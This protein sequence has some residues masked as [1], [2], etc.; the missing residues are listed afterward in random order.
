MECNDYNNIKQNDIPRMCEDIAEDWILL[1]YDMSKE[2]ETKLIK[3]LL[4]LI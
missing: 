3:L 4:P 1:L 2:I